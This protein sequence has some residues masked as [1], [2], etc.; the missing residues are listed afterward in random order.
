MSREKAKQFVERKSFQ[1]FIISL[2]ILNAIT[3]GMETSSE[4][5]I[6]FGR[7]LLLI[8]KIILIIFVIEIL[9]KLYAYGFGFFKGG[10]NIFDFS[11]VAIALLPAS[12]PLAILRALRIFRS[13]RLIKNVPKLRFIVESLFHSLPSLVWIFVLLSL[14]FYVFSVIGTKLFGA[15]YPQWFGNLGA[16]MFSLFQIMTLEGWAEISRSIME[17]YPLA[18][19]YFILFILLASYTTLN[20]F[21]AI[22][23]NT[24]AEVQQKVS[25]DEISKIEEFIQ[26]ENEEL[27]QNIRLIKEQVIKIE[28]R[29]MK[30]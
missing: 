25:E 3:I 15:D 2:I 24:M 18:N 4:I 23:V 26:D 13:L 12:G 20:I 9:L 7:T 27:K 6:L 19:I 28:E 11:I 10:W 16:S 21:I 8:D 5:M 22:V 1:N 14:V 29:L 17:K 30:K